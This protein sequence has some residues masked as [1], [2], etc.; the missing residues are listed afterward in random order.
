MLVRVALLFVA[1]AVLHTWPLASDPAH[2]S[3][4]DSPD[5]KLNAWIVSWVVHQLPRDPLRLFDANIF[6]PAPLTLAYSEPL[7]VPA[8]AAAPL[9]WLGASPVA[10]YNTLVLVG[11]V[12]S[13]LA[14]WALMLRVTGNNAAAG[15]AGALFAFNAHTL[16]RV[17]HLQ[18]FHTQWL[19]LSVWALDRVL[20][21]TT[22]R[23][24]VG[25]TLCLVLAAL[26]SGHLAVFVAVALTAAAAV[27][28][29]E[30]G[31]REG[32]TRALRLGG[33][34]LAAAVV[35][36]VTLWP[37]A[38]A[39][40]G[41]AMRRPLGVSATLD[42]YLATGGRLHFSLWSHRFYESGADVLFPG[43][44]ALGLAAVGLWTGR[45][46]S[47]GT[48]ML[49]AVG[50]V[51]LLLSL[52]PAT[53]VYDWGAWLFPPLQGIRAPS[54]LGFLVLFAVAGLAGFGLS[55]VQRWCQRRGGRRAA[56]AVAIAALGLVTV[57]AVRAPMAYVPFDGLSPLYAA[58]AEDPHGGS[59]VEFPV[60][61][62]AH[63]ARNA[64]YVLASTDHWRPLVNGYSGF[65]PPG[66]AGLARQL[67]GFPDPTSLRRL[68]ALGVRHVV[69]HPARYDDDEAAR[70]IG[71]LAR[72][73]ALQLLHVDPQGSR[74]YRTQW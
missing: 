58:I 63:V 37:Y 10:T 22:R 44:T 26:T 6:H 67:Q 30:W 72:A 47:P 1:L 45:T 74:L 55:A 11:L 16:T 7:I 46:R 73:T 56:R 14:M 13:A 43:F 34:I 20:T 21:G 70:L 69:V 59:V 23:D 50:I 27:R 52:G 54:R 33:S 61:A 18:A 64:D 32:K 39:S 5:T 17:P 57:E 28:A 29:G 71:R 35:V 4:V 36:A 68:R 25:L 65:S 40:D 31:S 49:A 42:Q 2:L 51:G 48:R 38:V 53:P 66:F 60:Y 15:L 62:S 19:P 8:V 41:G 3:R 12:T 24:A 9:R